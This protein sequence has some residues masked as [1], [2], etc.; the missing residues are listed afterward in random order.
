MRVYRG[1]PTGEPLLYDSI[2]KQLTIRFAKPTHI[3]LDGDIL[4]PM[5]RLVIDVPLRVSLI[6]G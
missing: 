1:F 2:G 3:M 4:E 6:Q 5:D